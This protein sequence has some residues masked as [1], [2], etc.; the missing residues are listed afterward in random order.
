MNLTNVAKAHGEEFDPEKGLAMAISKK[1]LGTGYYPEIKKWTKK[2]YQKKTFDAAMDR[3][4]DIINGN[5]A[6]K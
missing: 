1:V 5:V 6:A 3:V 2:Y 4:A